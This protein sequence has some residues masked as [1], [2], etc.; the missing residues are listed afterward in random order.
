M[1][2]DAGAQLR[3]VLLKQRR[4]LFRRRGHKA[5]TQLKDDRKHNRK[6]V[7]GSAA[8]RSKFIAVT[9][10]IANQATSDSQRGGAVRRGLCSRTGQSGPRVGEHPKP[11]SIR[12]ERTPQYPQSL[13]RNNIRGGFELSQ[14]SGEVFFGVGEVVREK[15]GESQPCL[16]GGNA[17]R[18]KFAKPL[19]K[20][21]EMPV[22][23]GGGVYLAIL[24]LLVRGS[25]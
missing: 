8:G 17:F 25:R 6:E 1:L 5:F 3:Q 10:V 16:E 4:L 18:G 2:K 11:G 23:G 19:V 13:P 9:P 15:G 20:V 22:I 12:D 7:R 24:K 21:E 14:G